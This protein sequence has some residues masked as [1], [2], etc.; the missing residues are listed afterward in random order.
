MKLYGKYLFLLIFA[1]C[2]CS[3]T[4]PS[5]SPTETLKEYIEAVKSKDISKIKQ[6]SSR[7]SLRLM[8][9]FKPDPSLSLEES[10]QQNEP[11]LPP[12]LQNPETRNEKINGDK[13]TVE[14]HNRF[15]DTWTEF[16]FVKEDGRWK[17]GAGEMFYDTIEEFKEKNE[18]VERELENYNKKSKK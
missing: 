15:N 13:A 1:L 18:A 7:K 3:Q 2:A 10:I 17:I 5:P 4:Q 6:T 16:L 8:E 12:I 14:I 11:S 9:E